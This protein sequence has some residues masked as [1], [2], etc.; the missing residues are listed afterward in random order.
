MG[1]DEVSDGVQSIGRAGRGRGAT[2]VPSGVSV[3]SGLVYRLP[4]Q[5]LHG[6]GI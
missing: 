4:G 2:R 3:L 6:L 5:D 1:L